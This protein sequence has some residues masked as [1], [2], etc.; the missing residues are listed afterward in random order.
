M[1]R[2][3]IEGVMADAEVDPAVYDR[4]VVALAAL[5]RQRIS[6]LTGGSTT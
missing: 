3:Y 5:A 4:R 1:K 6:A 2:R